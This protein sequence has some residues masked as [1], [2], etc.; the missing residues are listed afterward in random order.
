MYIY[1]GSILIMYCMYVHISWVYTDHV[2]YVCIAWS[3]SGQLCDKLGKP[4]V[5]VKQS[6]VI[7]I[8]VLSL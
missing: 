3:D 8:R 6:K 2:L 1:H 4:G 5:Y 7:A